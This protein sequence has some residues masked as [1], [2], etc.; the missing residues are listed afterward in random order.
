MN[1]RFVVI[2]VIGLL[3]IVGLLTTIMQEPIQLLKQLVFIAVAI[4]LFFF[5]Y[6]LFWKAQ[7][8]RKEQRAF[9]KA[10]LQS[11]KRLKKRQQKDQSK[12]PNSWKKEHRK[13]SNVHLTVIEGKK[14]KKKNRAL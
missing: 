11:K 13:R 4:G 1:V 9:R 8:K 10:A 5:F 7:P 3:A 12:R 6:H 2:S 14:G